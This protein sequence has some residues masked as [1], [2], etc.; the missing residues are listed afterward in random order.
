MT[1]CPPQAIFT[2]TLSSRNIAGVG[3]D[4]LS[5]DSGQGSKTLDA[6]KIFGAANVWGIENMANLESLPTTGYTIF[7]M[8]QKIRDGSGGASR[9][10]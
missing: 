2:S 9:L 7:N 8:V 10:A 5:T 1:P 3:V 4:T 6:H